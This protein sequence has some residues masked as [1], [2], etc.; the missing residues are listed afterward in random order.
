MSIDSPADA[1]LSRILSSSKQLYSMTLLYSCT[2]N[3]LR[4]GAHRARR[5]GC[6][7]WPS[8]SGHRNQNCTM[9]CQS[10]CQR[11][12]RDSQQVWDASVRVAGTL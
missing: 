12:C 2:K 3:L 11:H 1:A 4:E 8:V 6:W 7:S 9:A 5:S 10:D